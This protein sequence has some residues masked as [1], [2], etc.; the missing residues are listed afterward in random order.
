M[1]E[2]RKYERNEYTGVQYICDKPGEHQSEISLLTALHL[3][4]QQIR[5]GFYGE[6]QKSCELR[7]D[8]IRVD[9][10]WNNRLSSRAHFDSHQAVHEYVHFCGVRW[11]PTGCT[12][13]PS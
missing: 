6:D 10:K 13:Q 7:W 4:D 2:E 3:G 12:V 11:H 8:T 9:W 1:W 5:N